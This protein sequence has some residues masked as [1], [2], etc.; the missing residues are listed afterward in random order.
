MVDLLIGSGVALLIGFYLGIL[1]MALLTT[2]AALVPA[3]DPRHVPLLQREWEI[4]LRQGH[5]DQAGRSVGAF[6][7]RAPRAPRRGL[8]RR[9]L[10]ATPGHL[11]VVDSVDA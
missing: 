6:A 7:K 3:P 11:H 8:Q 10:P 4:R 9:T 5:G 2:S 1:V